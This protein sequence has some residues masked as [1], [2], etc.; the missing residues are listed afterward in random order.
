M[1][2]KPY[3]PRFP[4]RL[5]FDKDIE[6]SKTQQQ[7]RDEADIN[8]ILDKYLQTGRLDN[9]KAAGAMFGTFPAM[10]YQQALNTVRAAQEAFYELPS[11]IRRQ[12]GNDAAAFVDFMDN[13]ENVPEL[14]RM[15]F[16]PEIEK[17]PDQGEQ[18]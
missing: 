5:E 3:E 8:V 10:D 16:L 11:D 14:R 13:P 17:A 6:P 2:K 9:V 18:P 4:Q 12:F 1:F 7:F 15:G